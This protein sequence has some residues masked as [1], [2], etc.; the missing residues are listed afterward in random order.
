MNLSTNSFDSLTPSD[1]FQIE[2]SQTN[3]TSEDR[4]PWTN[5]SINEWRRLNAR[6]SKSQFFASIGRG[7]IFAG[8][9]VCLLGSILTMF[10]VRRQVKQQQKPVTT[11]QL[12]MVIVASMDL[13]YMS[14]LSGTYIILLTPYYY[15]FHWVRMLFNT[16][17]GLS[18]FCSLFSDIL[19]LFITVERFVAIRYPHFYNGNQAH[20]K[21]KFWPAAATA[22]VLVSA[23]RLHYCFDNVFNLIYE[24][25]QVGPWLGALAFFSDTVLPFSLLITM[26]FLTTAVAKAMYDRKKQVKAISNAQKPA[27]E[28]TKTISLLLVLVVMYLL[29]QAGYVFYSISEFVYQSALDRLTFASTYAE[30]ERYLSVQ[31]YYYASALAGFIAGNV[32]RSCVFFAYMAFNKR[33]RLD[34]VILLKSWF[35]QTATSSQAS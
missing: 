30:V 5:L 15:S 19:T 32:S 34:S 7:S 12:I 2:E 18:F 25:Y 13:L 27:D 3:I 23:T 9:P 33:F 1:W 35:R 31:L 11:F 16:M 29:N 10:V 8:T 22:S 26:L 24:N 14:L 20:L 21:N 6:T 4:W 17:N 28:A